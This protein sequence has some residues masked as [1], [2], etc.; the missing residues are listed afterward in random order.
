[1]GPPG[2]VE[3][4]PVANDPR[5]VLLGLEAVTVNALLLE[6][7]DDPLNHPVL[8]WAVRRDELLTK[9]LTAHHPREVAGGEDQSVVRSQQKWHR[10]P[11]QRPEACDQRLLQGR[12]RGRRFATPGEVPAE[13]F[14]GETVDD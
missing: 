8:L 5:G 11:S 9:P 1:M 14:T 6:G 12:R 4:D 7:T 2:V 3:L 10:H 13:Q